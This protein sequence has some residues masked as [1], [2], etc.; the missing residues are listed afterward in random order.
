MHLPC[1]LETL[2][3]S[4]VS[5]LSKWVFL[6]TEIAVFVST[7]AVLKNLDQG[8]LNLVETADCPA[9]FHSAA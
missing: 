8:K 1:N 6:P 4:A 5:Q 3:V 7:T 2:T 9:H